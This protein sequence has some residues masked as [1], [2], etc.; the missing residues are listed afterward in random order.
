[1]MVVGFLLLLM[2]PPT[3]SDEHHIPKLCIEFASSEFDEAF[4]TGYVDG[5]EGVIECQS[6]EFIRI[7]EAWMESRVMFIA[8]WWSRLFV[9]GCKLQTPLEEQTRRDPDEIQ[10]I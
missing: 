1:M 6:K 8:G 9:F 2:P 4:V 5:F 3:H 7:F 10:Y